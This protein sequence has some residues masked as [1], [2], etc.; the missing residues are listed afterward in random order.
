MFRNLTAILLSF[1]L[2]MSMLTPVVV[3]F[4]KD[5]FCSVL[6]ECSEEDSE[7]KEIDTSNIEESSEKIHA[8]FFSATLCYNSFVINKIINPKLSINGT[9]APLLEIQLP[10]P[11]Y[12]A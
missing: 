8:R 4:S 12:F 11:E 2:T 7:E 10:P 1:V 3:S 6:L 5:D 9:F